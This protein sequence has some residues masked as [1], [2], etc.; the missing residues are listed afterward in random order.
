MNLNLLFIFSIFFLGFQSIVGAQ[1]SLRTTTP[2][3]TL[4]PQDQDLIKK[5]REILGTEKPKNFSDYEHFCH[6]G[7]G[8]GKELTEASSKGIWV[9]KNR[10]DLTFHIFYW[11]NRKVVAHKIGIANDRT[12]DLR[13]LSLPDSKWDLIW[14]GEDDYG[15][16]GECHLF[17]AVNGGLKEVLTYPGDSQEP[18]G[19]IGD[20]TFLLPGANRTLTVLIE[21]DDDRGA[22]VSLE[23][24]SQAYAWN[25]SEKMYKP[26]L[27]KD[28]LSLIET[29]LTAWGNQEF[30][31]GYDLKEVASRPDNQELME[32]YI[33]EKGHKLASKHIRTFLDSLKP[34]N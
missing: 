18:T 26:T 7:L 15:G 23:F 32:K 3:L 17:A 33:R 10:Y 20:Y 19:R 30:L 24:S 11:R 2:I 9:G 28:K 6:L 22:A 29:V 34:D 25:D 16:G 14:I 1:S 13:I 8:D 4:S 12:N 31:S 21:T 5:A 27:S